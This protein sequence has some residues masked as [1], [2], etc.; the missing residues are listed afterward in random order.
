[1]TPTG[2]GLSITMKV[3]APAVS[4]GITTF[5]PETL[6]LSPS[7]KHPKST[8]AGGQA[9]SPGPPSK[10]DG[11]NTVRQDRN[12]TGQGMEMPNMTPNLGMSHGSTSGVT[13]SVFW[14]LGPTHESPQGTSDAPL[15]TTRESQQYITK[16]PSFLTARPTGH[17]VWHPSPTWETP[18]NST[19]L[20]NEDPRPSSFP[21][22]PSAPTTVAPETPACGESSGNRDPS[23]NFGLCEP[24][25]QTCWKCRLCFLILIVCGLRHIYGPLWQQ[26]SCLVREK[27][28]L[29]NP[30]LSP[31]DF[32]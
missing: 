8:S 6:T 16:D 11:G 15:H 3:T 4:T 28:F 13:S 21:G 25:C 32:L 27:R 23:W 1:M 9:W 22:P 20:Q 7:S 31:F 30:W 10:R 2:G 29:F 12:S 24:W 26:V 17:V 5:G 19:R 14:A 18:L